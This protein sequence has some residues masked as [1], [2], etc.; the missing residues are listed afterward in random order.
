MLFYIVNIILYGLVSVFMFV[1][2]LLVLVGYYNDREGQL[3]FGVFKVFLVCVI[4]FVIY[5]IYIEFVSDFID[6][7]RFK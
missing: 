6:F 4:L 5:F 3:L 2:F 1:V 7:C